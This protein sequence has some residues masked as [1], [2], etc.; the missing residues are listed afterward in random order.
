MF[1]QGLVKMTNVII[2][3]GLSLIMRGEAINVED[4]IFI[5]LHNLEQDYFEDCVQ[6]SPAT[7]IAFQPAIQSRLLL[8]TNSQVT[9]QQSRVV[10]ELVVFEKEQLFAFLKMSF[11]RIAVTILHN[12]V[13]NFMIV[14]FVLA[15]KRRTCFMCHLTLE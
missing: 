6:D 10:G 5:L 12:V 1:R 4:K 3:W 8:H 14:N 2:D 15:L 9:D 7:T 11:L 13:S